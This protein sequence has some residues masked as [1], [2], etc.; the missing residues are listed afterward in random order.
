[1]KKRTY[2]KD[3]LLYELDTNSEEMYVIQSGM[4]EIV[5]TMDKGKEEFVI[6]RLYRGSVINHNSFL[7]SDGIDTD[8]KC[9]TTVTVFYI[10]I[11]VIN[12]MRYKYKDFDEAL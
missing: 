2:E 7:M 6:E 9:K 11:D 4:V 1:M 10:E 5:H 8:A 12:A 3:S